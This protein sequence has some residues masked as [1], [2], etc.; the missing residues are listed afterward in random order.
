MTSEEK[1]RIALKRHLIQRGLT[2]NAE[3]NQVPV[4]TRSVDLNVLTD[5]ILEYIKEGD[6]PTPLCQK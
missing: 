6:L 3:D 1:V 2:F 5:T 4:F